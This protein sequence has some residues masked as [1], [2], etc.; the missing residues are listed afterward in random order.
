MTC[1]KPGLI[2]VSEC[3]YGVWCMCAV[4]YTLLPPPPLLGFSQGIFPRQGTT[5]FLASVVFP[6]D[7]PDKTATILSGLGARVGL[8]GF[9]AV[10]EGIHA[11]VVRVS[12]RECPRFVFFAGFYVIRT[13]LRV[14]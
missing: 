6:R 5:S 7:T 14:P 8:T 13:Y 9:G 11:E 2:Q 12:S 1:L 3:V 4:H 10:L